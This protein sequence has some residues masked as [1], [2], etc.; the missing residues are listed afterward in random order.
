MDAPRTLHCDVHTFPLQKGI[1]AIQGINRH[2][3]ID[4]DTTLRAVH[5]FKFY[6]LASMGQA[7]WCF[8]R[9]RRRFEH[10]G[11]DGMVLG[12][13]LHHLGLLG[14]HR[15]AGRMVLVDLSM[16]TQ[17]SIAVVHLPWQLC[18]PFLPG[19]NPVRRYRSSPFT[20]F[21]PSY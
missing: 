12:Y 7:D 20:K 4:L 8:D 11:R 14:R 6:R 1:D 5:A 17:L 13:Y 18:W 9:K 21:T 10:G 16:R 15:G 19:I 3:R 2:P